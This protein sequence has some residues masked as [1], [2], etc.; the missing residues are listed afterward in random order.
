MNNKKERIKMETNAVKYNSR[1]EAITA[2]RKMKQ[3]KK[4]WL[5]Q[6]D[7][8]FKLMRESLIPLS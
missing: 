2:F 3:R 7:Y 6:T 5:E 1:E 8:E 4:E